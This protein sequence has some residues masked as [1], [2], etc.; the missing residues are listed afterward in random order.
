MKTEV[1]L[2]RP[3]LDGIVR[4]SNQ[5]EYL[6]V[7]D[8]LI[9]GNR[10]RLN[11]GLNVINYQYWEKQSNTQEFLTHLKENIGKE[12]ILSKRGKTGERW[13]HP[14]AFIDLALYLNP[15]LKLTVYEWI[16]DQL[17]KYR[18]N[19][20][21]SY[22][23]MA[24]ALWINCTNKSNYQKGMMHV[25]E[26]IKNACNVNK[27]ENASEQQLKLRDK[28]HENISLLCDVLKDPNQAVNIGIK[29]AIE[30]N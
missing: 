3:L 25:A 27:W 20:G 12:P 18:N 15:K 9:I 5:N 4:Q 21:D 13:M 1:F 26:M 6:N 2:Q 30:D 22:K 17:I 23:K 28:I 8:L 11:N 10:W 14:F 16:Y 7:N 24:G 19:S 29:K